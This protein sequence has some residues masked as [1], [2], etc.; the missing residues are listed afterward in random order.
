MLKK[1]MAKIGIGSA[2]IDTVFKTEHF[3]Q[4]GKAEG[5]IEVRGG[6]VEQNISA[7]TFQLMTTAKVE[8]EDGEVE[9]NH[10]IDS[11]KITDGFVLQP[12][13]ER[14]IP[15]SFTLNQETPITVLNAK[16]NICKVWLET[17]MDIDYAIDSKDRDYMQI[18]PS[19]IISHF[20][21][22]L[23]NNGYVMFKADVEKGYLNAQDFSSKS[24]IYQEIEF[25]PEGFFG[26]FKPI[27][28]V[29]L[30]FVSGP[31]QTNVFIELD[32]VNREDGYLP[33]TIPNET[34]YEQVE[35]ILREIKIIK[36]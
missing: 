8:R 15:F 13:D 17:N 16:N 6:E 32:R 30:S 26:I 7:I 12:K 22:A 23:S 4:G 35:D 25:K 11:Y 18:H 1:L 21:D 14:T 34:G 28:E 33:F 27:N 19:A 10:I 3:V 20:I 9:I 2:K 5:H 31:Q 29:E 36:D 24:G